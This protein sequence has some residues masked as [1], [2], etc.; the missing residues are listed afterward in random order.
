MGDIGIERREDGGRK[1]NA[2]H[3][4]SVV[5]EPCVRFCRWAGVLVGGCE[6]P[7]VCAW[8]GATTLDIL[9][10]GAK[11]EGR[12][13]RAQDGDRVGMGRSQTVCCAP[14]SLPPPP[15]TFAAAHVDRTSTCPRSGTMRRGR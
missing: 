12:W 5:C 2:Y 7:C 13:T 1:A 15:A 6:C 14:P 3:P 4:R 10:P 9:A 8:V 11:N